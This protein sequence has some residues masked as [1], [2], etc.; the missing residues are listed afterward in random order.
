M[1]QMTTH[2]QEARDLIPRIALICWLCSTFLMSC[3]K[4]ESLLPTTSQKSA[5]TI[6]VKDGRLFFSSK[7][8]Y[9][10]TINK[11]L[12]G[13][14]PKSVQDW[15]SSFDFEPLEKFPEKE[16]NGFSF[17]KHILNKDYQVRVADMII[18]IVGDSVYNVPADRKDLLD[19]LKSDPRSSLLSEYVFSAY[20]KMNKADEEHSSARIPAGYSDNVI[21]TD[22]SNT[23]A[24]TNSGGT[25]FRYLIA[26]SVY[27]DGANVIFYL[28]DSLQYFWSGHGWYYANEYARLEVRSQFR[29]SYFIDYGFDCLCQDPGFGTEGYSSGAV[30]ERTGNNARILIPFWSYPND[31]TTR[32]TTVRVQATTFNWFRSGTTQFPTVQGYSRLSLSVSGSN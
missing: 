21:D 20:K 29:Y 14:S 22:R 6:T 19:L 8:L 17:Y 15:I 7:E 4:E 11:K 31:N 13:K 27:C 26:L 2:T 32:G 9:S 5:G 23:Y 10:S 3:Q 25:E 1:K 28:Q 16:F 18:Q 24:G 12:L 30:S